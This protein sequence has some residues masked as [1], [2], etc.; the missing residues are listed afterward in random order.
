VEQN[1]TDQTFHPKWVFPLSISVAC[2]TKTYF[3]FSIVQHDFAST[4][5]FKML[6]PV[7][8][9]MFDHEGLFL[10]AAN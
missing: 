5:F 10:E 4:V 8:R 2:C 7:L 6:P 3:M 9:K 1:N